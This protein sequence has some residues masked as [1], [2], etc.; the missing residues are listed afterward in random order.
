MQVNVR[1]FFKNRREA[2]ITAGAFIRMDTVFCQCILQNDSCYNVFAHVSFMI[3]MIIFV[4]RTLQ[5][6]ANV[7]RVWVYRLSSWNIY[8]R[9]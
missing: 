3:S 4:N 1:L 9:E 6:R 8:G 5:T 7:Q 2:F